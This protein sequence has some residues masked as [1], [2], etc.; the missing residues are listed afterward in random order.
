MRRKLSLLLALILLCLPAAQAAEDDGSVVY[1]DSFS[2]MEGRYAL[3]FT[4]DGE[5]VSSGFVKA[6]ER[7]AISVKVTNQSGSSGL[8]QPVE[9]RFE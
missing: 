6:G 7:N 8:W 5:E 2:V 9:L 3:N 4:V 1:S